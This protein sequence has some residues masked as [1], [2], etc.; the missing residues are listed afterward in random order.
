MLKVSVL[1]RF[2][3]QESNLQIGISVRRG[4][5]GTCP[6]RLAGRQLARQGLLSALLDPLTPE[7]APAN[8]TPPEPTEQCPVLATALKPT[9]QTPAKSL[10]TAASALGSS[11]PAISTEHKEQRPKQTSAT[12]PTKPLPLSLSASC[13]ASAESSTLRAPT[14]LGV[15]ALP[16]QSSASKL[17][18]RT[19]LISDSTS[20]SLSSAMTN[21][22]L[23]CSLAEGPSAA[24]AAIRQVSS[25]IKL[26]SCSMKSAQV[27]GATQPLEG[28][29]AGSPLF[30]EQCNAPGSAS[31]RS[32]SVKHAASAVQKHTGLSA[33]AAQ[34]M[35]KDKTSRALEHPSMPVTANNL[36]SA[37]LGD[38]ARVSAA[39]NP[40][41]SLFL[42]FQAPQQVSP[43]P[44]L[45]AQAQRAA[46]DDLVQ[47][48][49]MPLSGPAKI[50][51]PAASN[52]RQRIDFDD[53]QGPLGE[54]SY[55]DAMH[56][57]PVCQSDQTARY[58]YIKGKQFTAK[59]YFQVL[60]CT[61]H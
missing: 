43:T 54:A 60:C 33:I 26:A 39:E 35:S 6:A 22:A 14:P 36:S 31:R 2:S 7:Q 42:G 57:T 15:A 3:I 45:L 61:G 29:F 28:H 19:L 53:A 5:G 58:K 21:Q 34:L 49:S 50:D 38:V 11:S 12:A 24:T 30:R 27:S 9:A 47:K 40:T 46:S 17:Q 20:R 41:T 52:K 37:I 48:D 25:A 13:G 4:V 55:R 32:S 16:L 23:S 59:Y 10:H 8:A 44:T 56:G 51:I 18:Q 1:C